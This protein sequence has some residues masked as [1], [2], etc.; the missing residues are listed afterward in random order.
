MVSDPVR[1]ESGDD[2]A[3]VIE[4]DEG[5]VRVSSVDNHLNGGRSAPKEFF[6]ESRPDVKDEE[7]LLGVDGPGDLVQTR[8]LP[9]LFKD[10]RALE[11]LDDGAGGRALI[12]VV[13]RESDVVEVKGRSVPVNNELY[14]G[15]ADDDEPPLRVFEDGKELLFYEREDAE[16]HGV[17]A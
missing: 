8:D 16:K 2:G 11:V 3:G 6:R 13:D 17:S 9:C 15:G 10:R 4:G 5:G 14:D 7:G 1:G 12:L